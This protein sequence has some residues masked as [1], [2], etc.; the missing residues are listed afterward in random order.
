MKKKN[1]QQ[2]ASYLFIHTE[3]SRCSL[4][5]ER[6][7]SSRCSHSHTEMCVNIIYCYSAWLYQIGFGEKKSLI[8]HARPLKKKGIYVKFL[9]KWKHMDPE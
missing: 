2:K 9:G 5:P 1:W 6:C 4:G 8:K 3:E 7:L